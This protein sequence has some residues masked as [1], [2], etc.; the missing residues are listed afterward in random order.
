MG[1]FFP[2]VAATVAGAA[3]PADA[4]A[5]SLVGIE[6]ALADA[7]PAGPLGP[8][9]GAAEQPLL[10]RLAAE[11]AL[12]DSVRAGLPGGLEAPVATLIDALRAHRAISPA[13]RTALPAWTIGPPSDLGLLR[14]AY[15]SAAD[16]EGV[17]WS[18][19]AAVHFVETRFGRIRA[20]SVS[21]ALGP[22]QFLPATWAAYGRG[23]D[24]HDPMDAIRGAAH[25][26]A[27]M[28]GRRDLRRA[29]WHYNHHASYVD[30]VLG[31]AGLLAAEPW[32]LAGWTGWEVVYPTVRGD[33]VLPIGYSAAER[34]P[35]AV[36]CATQ[37]PAVCPAD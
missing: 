24:V 14:E 8:A 21:G 30:A 22:M 6:L 1:A 29:L 5:A 28:G 10:R 15:A 27:A 17:P 3:P 23:G 18:V 35:V 26:L 37:D 12:W 11:P 2:L 9:L 4:V 16:A 32:R 13:P 20:T 25:Y 33:I 7:P 19:L 34:V 31:F 36:Y